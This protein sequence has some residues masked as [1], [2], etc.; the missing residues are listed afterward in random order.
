MVL[1]FC[2]IEE[3]NLP[4]DFNVTKLN[5]NVYYFKMRLIQNEVSTFLISINY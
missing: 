4:I 3:E 1:N 5:K 2:H